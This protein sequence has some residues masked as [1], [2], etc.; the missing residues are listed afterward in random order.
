MVAESDARYIAE[1]GATLQH[2]NNIVLVSLDA[3]AEEL[4]KTRKVPLRIPP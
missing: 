4:R 2:S 3:D 1:A